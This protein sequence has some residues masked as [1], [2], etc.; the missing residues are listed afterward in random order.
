MFVVWDEATPVPN[1]VIAPHTPAGARFGGWADHY[2]LLR[3]TD[4]LLGLPHLGKA[5]LAP[6]LRGPF[7]L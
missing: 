5:G 3:P 2:A 4:D 1:L 7:H 6:S